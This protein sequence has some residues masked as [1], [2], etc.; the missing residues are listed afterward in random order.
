MRNCARWCALSCKTGHLFVL[1]WEVKDILSNRDLK[2]FSP[3]FTIGGY[4]WYDMRILQ[5]RYFMLNAN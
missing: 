5:P 2:R 3:T 1:Q 4:P